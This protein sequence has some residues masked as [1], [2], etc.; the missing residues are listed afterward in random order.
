[1]HKPP[2]DIRKNEIVIEKL[3]IFGRQKIKVRAV[4]IMMQTLHI[5]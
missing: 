2:Q 3:M 4:L 1:M 5:I